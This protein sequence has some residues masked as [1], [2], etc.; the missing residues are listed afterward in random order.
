MIFLSSVNAE[1]LLLDLKELTNVFVAMDS[2][3]Q[4]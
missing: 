4:F 2:N 1:L 3:L